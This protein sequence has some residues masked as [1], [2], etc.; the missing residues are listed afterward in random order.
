VTSNAMYM[1]PDTLSYK[2]DEMAGLFLS[3]WHLQRALMEKSTGT[4]SVEFVGPQQMVRDSSRFMQQTE[5]LI[6]YDVYEETYRRAEWSNRQNVEWRI[7][8]EEALIQTLRGLNVD[9]SHAD[10]Q[11]GMA[12][13]NASI[14]VPFRL[15]FDARE[16]KEV[17][18]GIRAPDEEN[19]TPVKMTIN[20]PP[21]PYLGLFRT[22]ILKIIEI[23]QNKT[24]RH[25]GEEWLKILSEMRYERKKYKNGLVVNDEWYSTAFMNGVPIV[26]DFE[27]L[28]KGRRRRSPTLYL[29]SED[30]QR[31]DELERRFEKFI[32][33]YPKLST[34]Y[35]V[36]A[37]H[38]NLDDE[39]F[40]LK[41]RLGER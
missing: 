12:S 5:T 36:I 20:P 29:L 10:Y 13:F 26:V 11:R 6:A 28:E 37:V 33:D 41:E 19:P 27:E 15:E 4:N 3:R 9:F 38:L 39:Y 24:T 32:R 40:A 31:L 25:P 7:D 17:E 1:P 8:H 18:S 35:G 2:V 34:D 14:Y 23:C 22:R 16:W 30:E 21:Y